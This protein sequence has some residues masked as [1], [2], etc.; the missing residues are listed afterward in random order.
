[1]LKMKNKVMIGCAL[2]LL[3]VMGGIFVWVKISAPPGEEWIAYQNEALIASIDQQ[4]EGMD[5]ET[6]MA[7]KE[8]LVLERDIGELQLAVERG[9]LSYEEITA[10]YLYR[11]RT[12][13][14]GYHGYNSVIEIA[15]DALKQA[16]AR[17]EARARRIAAGEKLPLLYGIPVMFKDNINTKDMP[18]S[19]GAAAFAEF[20]PDED[21]ELVHE[22]REQECV[23]L[24]KNNLSEFAYYVSSKMPSGYSGKKGQT[25]NPFG[26]L[27]ISPSGSSSG[28]AVAVTANLV[29]VSIG[30]E[31]AGSIVGPAAVNSV[32]GFKPSRESMPREGIFP[33]IRAVDTPGPITKTVRD[34]A[35]VYAALSGEAIP[36]ELDRAALSRASVGLIVYDYNDEAA[37]Q[38]LRSSLETAGARIV[39]VSMDQMDIQV[40]TII[41]RTFK[42]DFEEFAQHYGLPI[43]RLEALIQFNREDIKRRAKYGQDNLEAA[44]AI[45]VPD[46]TPIQ[47]SIVN[48]QE[49]LDTLLSDMELDAIVFLNTTVSTTV[50]AAG[51]PEL[52]VPLGVNNKGVPQGATFAAGRGEDIKLLNLGY[53]F[54]QTI[55]G[56][57]VPKE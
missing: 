30:T 54:E 13:D 29:P 15:P 8:R 36:S 34:A 10:I 51:Y 4:L 55:Q 17:D 27:K 38:M 11:I 12:L 28:S 5:M 33:L 21:A 16:R 43:T 49:K 7:D 50:S 26:P 18:T 6:L 40:Q 25:V 3:L 14:Q 19:A 39:D 46:D 37:I 1:M 22:L 47:S 24:G 31:T 48:A 42:R 2:V 41:E 23:I 20:I 53:A 45:E 9:E 56:R 32:V 44:N 52:T 57:H 35:I